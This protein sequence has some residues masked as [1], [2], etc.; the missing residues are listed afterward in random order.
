M[1]P[2]PLSTAEAEELFERLLAR[3]RKQRLKQFRIWS[4][5]AAIVGT[6]LIAV[7]AILLDKS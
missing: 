5:W 1:S 2:Q 6:P 4:E 3:R 7:A